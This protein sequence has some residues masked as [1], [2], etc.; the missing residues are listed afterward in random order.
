MSGPVRSF[1]SPVSPAE[2][3][4]EPAVL[5]LAGLRFVLELVE[6]DD[7]V[8]GPCAA[9]SVQAAGVT[10]AGAETMGP[11]TPEPDTLPGA[12]LLR[13]ALA[14]EALLVRD[15]GA[16]ESAEAAKTSGTERH[17]FPCLPQGAAPEEQRAALADVRRRLPGLLTPSAGVA[18]GNRKVPQGH[19]NLLWW[20]ERSNFGDVVGP[21]LVR[22]I[23]GLQPV[24]GWRRGLDVPPLAAVGS[25]AGWLEQDGTQVWGAGLM[26]A[27]DAA[28]VER[29]AAL[30]GIRIHA[31]RGKLTAAELRSQLGWTV[32]EIYGD[33]ALLLPR[34]LPVQDGQPSRGKVAVVPHLDHRG[35]LGSGGRGP[36]GQG[37]DVWGPD[38]QDPEDHGSDVW[39]P[40]APVRVVDA[41]QG[42]EQV[43]REIAGSRACISSSLHGI[44]VAQAYGVPWTWVRIS[45]A[46]IAGDTFKFRDFFSTLRESEVSS[47]DVTVA[48][49]GELDPVLLARAATLPRLRISLDALL[50]AFPL[51]RRA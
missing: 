15:D 45:D 36:A 13:N 35:I 22:R 18:A 31:V 26:R 32:P 44:I 6:V 47:V 12:A 19:V 29:L 5:E 39:G 2:Q 14:G 42:M 24:N 16:G 41:R 9:V 49:A 43:V 48:Q 3:G 46:V 37:S 10:G 4:P 40:D 30:R 1:L 51:P 8:R 27:L 23:S 50:E 28:A 7:G 21:W 33:P 17:L 34:F 11:E 38:A 20:D 25:T